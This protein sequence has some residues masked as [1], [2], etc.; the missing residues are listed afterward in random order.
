MKISVEP[1]NYNLNVAVYTEC[2]CALNLRT[3]LFYNHFIYVPTVKCVTTLHKHYKGW[4]Q[5]YLPGDIINI[6]KHY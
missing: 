1:W 6:H 4:Y 3:R 2:K 5:N